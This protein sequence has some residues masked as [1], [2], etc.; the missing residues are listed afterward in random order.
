MQVREGNVCSKMNLNNE[1]TNILLSSSQTD[2]KWECGV[3]ILRRS[4]A[5]QANYNCFGRA[6]KNLTE[7]KLYEQFLLF[8]TLF[9]R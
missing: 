6:R 3:I 8:F 5:L 2:Y 9:V 1:H 7:S 4:E